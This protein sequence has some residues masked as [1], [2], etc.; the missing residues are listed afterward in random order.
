MKYLWIGPGM[1]P[2]TQEEVISKGGKI[3]SAFI[4]QTNLVQGLESLG[5]DMDSINGPKMNETLFPTVSEERWS[6]NGHSE[7]VCVGYRNIK[8]LNRLTKE[9]ALCKEASA[10]LK[11]Q[12]NSDEITIFIYNMHTAYIAAAYHVKKNHPN[13]KIVLIV[14]DLPQYMDLSMGKLKKI[15]KAADWK[16][17]QGYMR[18]IDKYILYAKPMAEALGLKDGQWMVMEGSYDP[19]IL[20]EANEK[21]DKI[22]VMYS[23]VLDLRYGIPELLDAMK[24]LD[25]D[26]ELWLTGDG[27]A[28]GLIKERAEN[29]QRIKYFGFLPSRQDLL[30]KQ[31]S[32][33]MLISPRKDDEDA[34]K[35]CFPSKIFEYM[36]SGRPVISCY[37]EGIP[38]EYYD[39]LIE[40]K[41]VTPKE[42]AKTIVDTKTKIKTGVP[43]KDG[44]MFVLANKSKD[45]QTQK[46]LEFIER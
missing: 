4:S 8:Y 41:H 9:R 26:Y 32:A 5:I 6:R 37:L 7:D 43:F 2:K 15:L 12:K 42:I 20:G 21:S 40:L 22:S 33:S 29:D 38:E 19:D 24:L 16:R 27:N 31:A 35:Y 3:L 25:D 1:G 44:R 11:K 45:R 10:W 39:Y 36:V 18:Y 14:P 28:V 17:I 34:S 23:G 13:T 46:I 30:N